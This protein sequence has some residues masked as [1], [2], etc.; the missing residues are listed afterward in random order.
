MF[1]LQ[2]TDEIVLALSVLMIC[3][4]THLARR[5]YQNT[6]SVRS[7]NRQACLAFAS[8]VYAQVAADKHLA[9]VFRSGLNDFNAL[10]ASDKVRLHFFLQ[11]VVALF[12][13]SYNAYREKVISE[14]EFET[15]RAAIMA[16]LCMP[17]GKVWWQDAQNAYP[18][19]LRDALNSVGDLNYALGDIYPYFLLADGEEPS[20]LLEPSAE[21]QPSA[22]ENQSLLSAT[23]ALESD[24][25]AKASTAANEDNPAITDCDRI[26]TNDKTPTA[27]AMDW[28]KGLARRRTRQNFVRR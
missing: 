13:D 11:S 26:S 15:N 3:V 19:K 28:R 21:Q 24:N 22:E 10:E 2:L 20:V 25:F 23:S 27:A 8:E 16:I 6:R 12:N 4:I 18:Q 9:A 14:S 7:C 17:G 1:E 5:V